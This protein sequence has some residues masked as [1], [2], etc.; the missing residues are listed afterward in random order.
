[1]INKEEARQA[2]I[3]KGKALLESYNFDSLVKEAI[4]KFDNHVDLSIVYKEKD[5]LI[6][7]VEHLRFTWTYSKHTDVLTVFI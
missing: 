6:L 1:M 7:T 4:E 5:T 3:A 2:I